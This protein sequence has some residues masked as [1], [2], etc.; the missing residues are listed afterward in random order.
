[1]YKFFYYTPFTPFLQCYCLIFLAIYRQ[2]LL[3]AKYHTITEK[4]SADKKPANDQRISGIYCAV[5][6]RLLYNL[7]FTFRSTGDC[8]F[9]CRWLRSGRRKTFFRCTPARRNSRRTG[10]L[11]PTSYKTLPVKSPASPYQRICPSWKQKNR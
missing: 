10:R 5:H 7:F 4:Y 3:S 2:N 9:C 1:M 6:H 8:L 11:I